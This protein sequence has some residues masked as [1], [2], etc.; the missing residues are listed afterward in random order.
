MHAS[1]RLGSINDPFNTINMNFPI[2]S[3]TSSSTN[4]PPNLGNNNNMNMGKKN[5]QF[6][7]YDPNTNYGIFLIL[8]TTS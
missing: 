3:Q 2:I 7:Q 8:K 1:S 5:D 4:F 6:P